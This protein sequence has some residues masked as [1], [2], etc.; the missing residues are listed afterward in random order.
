MEHSKVEPRP[1]SQEYK[2][3]RQANMQKESRP[4]ESAQSAIERF[5]Q[6]PR[7]R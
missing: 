4:Y 2:D 6:I 5:K 1:T 3:W 7:L